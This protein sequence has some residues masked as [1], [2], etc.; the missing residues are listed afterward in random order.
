[1]TMKTNELRLGNVVRYNNQIVKVSGIHYTTIEFG[2]V[3]NDWHCTGNLAEVQPIELTEELLV[4]IGFEDR[5]G[6]F[7]Y[8]RVFDDEN[9]YCDSIHIY[10]CPMLEHFKFT[11]DKVKAD[12]LQT[13]D[14]Y[15]I[16]YLHQ[17][18]NAYYLLTGKELK[19]EL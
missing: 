14:L 12:D 2:E 7:N 17:L 6:Y 8:S 11:Y 3:G 15:N 10:Y 1:M 13:M 19:I 4:K 5:K 16:K 9:N 18:Q